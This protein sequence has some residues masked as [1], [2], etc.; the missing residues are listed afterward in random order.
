VQQPHRAAYVQ[1]TTSAR[2]AH[3][4]DIIAS[5]RALQSHLQHL[6]DEA[7]DTV[8]KWESDIHARELAEKRRVAPGWLDAE[9][10]ML[11]P[12]RRGDGA[13][14]DSKN[15]STQQLS[16][17][18]VMPEPVGREDLAYAAASREGE[19]LDRAFGSLESGTSQLAFRLK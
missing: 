11:V 8:R 10:R 16:H 17:R 3:P 9:Q 18:G 4:D 6:Q 13:E 15:A 14:M 5:C 2:S 19:E 12:E 1:S 7:A